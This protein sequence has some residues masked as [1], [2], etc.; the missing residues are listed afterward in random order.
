MVTCRLYLR[1]QTGM[2]RAQKG[3]AYSYDGKDVLK[4]FVEGQLRFALHGAELGEMYTFYEG[5]NGCNLDKVKRPQRKDH[6]LMWVLSFDREFR[7]TSRAEYE[8]HLAR[9]R[10]QFPLE[11]GWQE[12]TV[13]GEGYAFTVF[14]SD[15]AKDV[16]AAAYIASTLWLTKDMVIKILEEFPAKIR[17]PRQYIYNKVLRQNFGFTNK[18]FRELEAWERAEGKE[19]FRAGFWS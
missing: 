10:E 13:Q 2:A 9:R 11:R 1:K 19:I 12:Q 3:I 7:A 8:Q 15:S 14:T 4:V 16:R 18:D 6:S 17:F 5:L